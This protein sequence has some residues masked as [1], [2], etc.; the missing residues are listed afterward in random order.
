M[1]RGNL[2]VDLQFAPDITN[3]KT[4]FMSYTLNTYLLVFTDTRT[5]MEMSDLRSDNQVCHGTF[6]LSLVFIDMLLL[7]MSLMF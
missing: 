4:G 3:E 1:L 6:C 7:A 5:N 2:C